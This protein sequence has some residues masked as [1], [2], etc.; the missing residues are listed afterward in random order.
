MKVIKQLH[1]T[2]AA[3]S[4]SAEEYT[5]GRN[6][7]LKNMGAAKTDSLVIIT[8]PGK[9]DWEMP[10][11][12]E[13]AK[14]IMNDI[15]VY[16]MDKAG[17]NAQ[18]PPHVVADAMKQSDIALLVT[19]Y[20][21]THTH[22][23]EQA[24]HA[25]TRIASMPG[26]TH[27]VIM[28]TLSGNQEEMVTL[29]NKAAELLTH[30]KQVIL[31]SKNGTE[32]TLDISNRK[33]I[34]DTGMLD[35]KGDMGNLPG[36]EAFLAPVEGKTNG[37][38][39][40]DGAFGDITIDQPIT[41]DVKNGIAVNIDGGEGARLIN[42]RLSRVGKDAYSIAELGIG[43]N[44]R[45]KLNSILLEVEKVYETV[46]IA[47]GNNIHFGG[48]VDVPFHADGVILSPTL[49]IDGRD[50]LKGGRFVL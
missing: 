47:L 43:T 39:V 49:S 9:Q 14:K 45:A 40:F 15:T 21:L 3:R 6:C 24:K 48:E 1:T 38:I 10:I 12:F 44:K 34:P 33:G 42:K 19:S 28:R 35:H 31:T 50:V 11:F 16:I 27:E 23:T 25:G 5:I 29:T 4:L 17:E 20:S 18:E 26:I 2:D 30:G 13:S 36:G 37:R 32:V 7:L 46:H 22:A 8:D 41:V